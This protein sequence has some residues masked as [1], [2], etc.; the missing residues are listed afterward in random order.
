MKVEMTNTVCIP[1][2]SFAMQASDVI[3]S[4]YDYFNGFDIECIEYDEYYQVV[5]CPNQ[6]TYCEDISKGLDYLGISDEEVSEYCRI[7]D[8]MALCLSE[9][10]LP[11]AFSYLSEKDGCNNTSMNIIHVDD[12]SDLMSPFICFEKDKYY[13]MLSGDEIKFYDSESIKKAVRSGAI[14]IGSMLTAITYTMCQTNIIHIK[15]DAQPQEYAPVKDTIFDKMLR[16]GCQRI[17]INKQYSCTEK[18]RYFIT[19]D[20]NDLGNRINWELP[21]FLHIDMDYFNNRYNASTGWKEC[22]ERHDPNFAQQQ[23]EMDKLIANIESIKQRTCIKYVLIGISPSFYPVEYWEDGLNYLIT[24]LQRI[25]I[26]GKII[27]QSQR[28]KKH[29]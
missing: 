1:K 7:N 3:E 12:H 9:N 19:N 24:E 28:R 11:Y 18:N 8:N 23:Y 27:D 2:K 26:I 17:V 21:S 22:R 5:V 6:Y 14:T 29:E 10:W 16:G 20:W 25:G 4:I 13:N 15:N